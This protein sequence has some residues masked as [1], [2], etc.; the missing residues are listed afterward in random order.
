MNWTQEEWRRTLNLQT[1]DLQRRCIVY[2][3]E[4]LYT[5]TPHEI[6][7]HKSRTRVTH[8]II[9]CGNIPYEITYTIFDLNG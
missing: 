9:I 1:L 2:L 7:S 5:Y 3:C 6:V 4:P 8:N